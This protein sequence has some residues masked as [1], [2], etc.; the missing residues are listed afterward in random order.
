MEENNSPGAEGGES[1]APALPVVSKTS[2]A[3][4]LMRIVLF[5]NCASG[6]FM[7]MKKPLKTKPRIVMV[8]SDPDPG[9]GVDLGTGEDGK[10]P[11]PDLE[12]STGEKFLNP[13]VKQKIQILGPRE[14]F[15][16]LF[17][18]KFGKRN[19]AEHGI[20]DLDVRTIFCFS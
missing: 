6:L 12:S 17:K 3:A 9:L 4:I 8:A 16:A 18:S 10:I 11:S 1:I 7:G 5:N 13:S 15:F 20:V 14:H 2:K 19:T